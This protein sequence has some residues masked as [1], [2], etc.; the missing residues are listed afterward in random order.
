[1]IIM[2]LYDEIKTQFPKMA[3]CLPPKEMKKFLECDYKKLALYHLGL[4]T[5]IRNN[6]LQKN[7]SLFNTFLSCG[8]SEKDDMS[9]LM[10]RLFYIYLKPK[11]NEKFPK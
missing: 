8:I 1:M 7:S 4:G 5:W 11:Y 6:L 9:S 10:I 2:D 3:D